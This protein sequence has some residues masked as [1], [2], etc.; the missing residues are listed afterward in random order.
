MATV[1][2]PMAAMLIIPPARNDYNYNLRNAAYRL[3]PIRR[4]KAAIP[5][6]YAAF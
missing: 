4:S 1:T 6:G 2:V 5:L 3:L